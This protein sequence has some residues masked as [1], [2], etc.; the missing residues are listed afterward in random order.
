M[1]IHMETIYVSN[2]NVHYMIYQ[3]AYKTAPIDIVF[4]KYIIVSVNN[5]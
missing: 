4:V 3:K 5:F 1:H 2:K